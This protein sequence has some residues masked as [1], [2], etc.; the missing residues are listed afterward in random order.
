MPLAEIAKVKKPSLATAIVW[1]V[2]GKKRTL[3]LSHLGTNAHSEVVGVLERAAS[4]R[5]AMLSQ[6]AKLSSCRPIS[7]S[8][9]G[10]GA[11]GKPPLL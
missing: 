4:D 1:L 9:D 8:C 6:R 5:R 11:G 10:S 7:A 2:D 3:D